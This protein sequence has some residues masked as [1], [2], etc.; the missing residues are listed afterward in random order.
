MKLDRYP[1]RAEQKRMD[2]GQRPTE[3][4]PRQP[5][6][7]GGHPPRA[8]GPWTQPTTAMGGGSARDLALFEKAFPS[9]ME[10]VR[11]ILGGLG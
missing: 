7:E 6:P 10:Q 2:M 8:P 1:T 4:K 9:L 5:P 11:I 3:P